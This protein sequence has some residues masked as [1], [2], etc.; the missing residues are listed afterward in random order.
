MRQQTS[1]AEYR[2]LAEFRFLIQ[3]Y[4]NNTERAARA[5]GI[6]SQQYRAM[7][8]LR[9]LPAGL[10]PTIRNLAERLQGWLTWTFQQVSSAQRNGAERKHAPACSMSW[11]WRPSAW[12][13]K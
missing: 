2:A 4:Q 5:A 6:T 7:L 13:E 9:G 11:P 1:L 8:Q 12:N 3:R 10:E